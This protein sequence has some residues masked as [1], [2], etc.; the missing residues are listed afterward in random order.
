MDPNYP[1]QPHSSGA[2]QMPG[3]YV[4]ASAA[5]TNTDAGP[6]GAAS[7]QQVQQEPK[8]MQLARKLGWQPE[9]VR[10]LIELRGTADPEHRKR[11]MPFDKVL[12]IMQNEFGNDMTLSLQGLEDGW[13]HHIRRALPRRWPP[14]LG[15]FPPGTATAPAQG[16]QGQ[17]SRSKPQGAIPTVHPGFHGDP[18]AG[19]IGQPQAYQREYGDDLEPVDPTT[20]L[21]PGAVPTVYN[22]FSIDPTA[23]RQQNTSS[24]PGY[25]SQYVSMPNTSQN[26][27]GFAAVGDPANQGSSGGFGVQPPQPS[28]AELPLGVPREHVRQ[29]WSV[30]HHWIFDEGSRVN[31]VSYTW[32]QFQRDFDK[33]WKKKVN[34]EG[35]A[36]DEYRKLWCEYHGYVYLEEEQ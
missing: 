19:I 28:E 29:G 33:N 2:A 32:E 31:G 20:G 15:R 35:S 3:Y 12:P 22:T 10:R 14:R 7:Q 1:D 24:Q 8:E 18:G 36:R 5:P 13:Y 17:P 34:L 21:R 25:G 9:W 30:L 6:T 23:H 16:S 26:V 4:A 27:L 11:K